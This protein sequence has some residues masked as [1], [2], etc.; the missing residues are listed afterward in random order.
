M[1]HIDQFKQAMREAGFTPPFNVNAAIALLKAPIQD[2]KREIYH[3]LGGIML[4]DDSGGESIE[5]FDDHTA[6]H[7]FLKWLDA[8]REAKRKSDTI[9][10]RR[11]GIK[12]V[13]G[14][15]K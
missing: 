13:K 9:Q 14:G 6:I 12:L 2:R 4:L 5:S 8:T 15:R 10:W 1:S 7:Y 3:D 11:A